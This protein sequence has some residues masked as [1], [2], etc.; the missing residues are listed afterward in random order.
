[1]PR[2]LTLV[3]PREVGKST[4]P[5][6]PEVEASPEFWE[7]WWFWTAIGVGLTGTATAIFFAVDD[8]QQTPAPNPS[9]L[10][11][12]FQWPQR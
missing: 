1:M 4:P 8:Q 7:T 2:Q 11:V 9:G 6:P 3:T 5:E 12:E 10:A